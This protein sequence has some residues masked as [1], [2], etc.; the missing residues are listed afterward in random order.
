MVARSFIHDPTPEDQLTVPSG[1]VLLLIAH[2][3][4]R[5]IA[6][7]S[8]SNRHSAGRARLWPRYRQREHDQAPALLREP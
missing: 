6:T 5:T 4:K 1:R 3:W 2:G 8:A 7:R